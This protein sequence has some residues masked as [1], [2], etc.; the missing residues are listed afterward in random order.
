[1]W[2]WRPTEAIASK[3]RVAVSC[4]RRLP[5]CTATPVPTRGVAEARAT[6]RAEWSAPEG[7][8]GRFPLGCVTADP[9]RIYYPFRSVLGRGGSPRGDRYPFWVERVAI[10]GGRGRSPALMGAV[11]LCSDGAGRY[12]QGDPSK[13]PSHA[14][15][16]RDEARRVTERSGDEVRWP[17]AKRGRERGGAAGNEVETRLAEA[18]EQAMTNLVKFRERRQTRTD[19]RASRSYDRSSTRWPKISG[20]PRRATKGAR[21]G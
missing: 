20:R 14:H 10:A 12:R 19:A 1:M 7:T 2:N 3:I 5:M 11:A 15:G 9:E 13:T 21:S 4:R 8:A 17:D 18:D 6:R 16:R